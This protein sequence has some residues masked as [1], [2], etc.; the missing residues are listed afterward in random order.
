MLE[1]FKIITEEPNKITKAIIFVLR[2]VFNLILASKLYIYFIGNYELL[3]ITDYKSI[4][5][6]IVSGRVLLCILFYIFSDF[7][8]F[9]IISSI[10]DL[11]FK[12]LSVWIRNHFIFSLKSKDKERFFKGFSRMGMLNYDPINKK[13]SAGTNTIELYE[14]LLF[15]NQADAGSK[16]RKYKEKLV[17]EIIHNLVVFIVTYF[18]VLKM[19]TLSIGI[20]TII[21]IVFVLVT[22]VIIYMSSIFDYLIENAFTILFDLGGIKDETL[23]Y[24]IFKSKRHL[25]LD[26]YEDGI[27]KYKY[28]L[29]NETYYIVQFCY[30]RQPV[31]GHTIE[32]YSKDVAYSD[33]KLLIISNYELSN[34]AKDYLAALENIYVIVYEDEQD[35]VDKVSD[36]FDEQ[37]LLA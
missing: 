33:K 30:T 13:I 35:M 14:L 20:N 26:H 8:F 37:A 10:V 3:N 23:F 12:M 11:G 34:T 9:V 22:L 31:Q 16:F 2:S 28:V 6:F 21:I 29:Q 25:I 5:E 15:L 1:I 4:Y 36:F 27:L 24:S 19:G 32:M 18:L 17:K 7:I